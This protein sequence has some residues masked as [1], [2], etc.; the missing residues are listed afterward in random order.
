MIVIGAKGFAKELLEE[1]V[2]DKYGYDEKELFFFDD[3][4][5]S[6]PIK[7]FDKYTIL[8]NIKEMED[9]FLNTSNKFCLGLG[10]PIHRMNL[11]NKF[12]ELGG[13]LTSIISSSSKIGSFGTEIG[14]GTT[15]IGNAVITNGIKIGKGSLIYM[16]TSITHDA[17]IGDYVQISPGVSVLGRSTIGNLTLLGSNSVILPDIKI[18]SNCI[19]GAGTVVTKDI[20]DN[21]VVV[22]VP[23]KIIKTNNI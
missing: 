16:N 10:E 17:N 1:L 9:V 6:M 13:L 12:I 19:I 3:I 15:I 22:G 8:R 20:P 21:S 18:G 4:T 14:I 2:S 11:A 7:L 23:G 5:E